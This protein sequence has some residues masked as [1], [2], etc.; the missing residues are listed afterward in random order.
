VGHVT[1]TGWNARERDRA[2]R[3]LLALARDAGG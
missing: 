3:R 1:H 2:V